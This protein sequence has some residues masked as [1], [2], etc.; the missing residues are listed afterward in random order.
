MLSQTSE[1][2]IRA[3]LF[4]GLEGDGRPLSPRRLSERLGCSASYL[5]KTFNMLVRAGVLRSVRGS[6][7]GVLLARDP[8]RITMLDIIEACQGLL[9]GNYCQQISDHEEPVCSFHQ[10]MKEV[11]EGTV[12]RLSTWTLADLLSRPVKDNPEGYPFSCKMA[13]QGSEAHASPGGKRKGK[14]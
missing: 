1:L 4:L 9:I 2:A 11:H 13:F 14:K 7:G 8:E 12:S 6:H 3:L 10:A 5:A